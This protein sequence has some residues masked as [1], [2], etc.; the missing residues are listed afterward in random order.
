MH[1]FY[2]KNYKKCLQIVDTSFLLQ[3]IIIFM[4]FFLL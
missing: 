1:I 4:R 3:A 2:F